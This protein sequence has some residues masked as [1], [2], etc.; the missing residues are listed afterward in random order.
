MQSCKPRT[1]SEQSRSTPPGWPVRPMSGQMTRPA[2][3]QA[4]DAG[5]LDSAGTL[6]LSSEARAAER[7]VAGAASGESAPESPEA[8]ASRRE[9]LRAAGGDQG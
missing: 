8:R 7:A 3:M 6:R 9:A 5:G 4:S 2:Q 1:F